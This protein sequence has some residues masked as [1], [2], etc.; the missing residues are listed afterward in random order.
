MK[1]SLKFSIS[2]IIILVLSYLILPKSYHH[3]FLNRDPSI[4]K[5]FENAIEEKNL[6]LVFVGNSILKKDVDFELLNSLMDITVLD[7]SVNATTAPD[8]YLL[9]KNNIVT[10]SRRP[11]TVVIFFTDDRLTSVSSMRG[12]ENEKRVSKFA[13]A[14]ESVF[15]SLVYDISPLERF[16]LKTVTPFAYQSNLRDLMESPFQYGLPKLVYH[17]DPETLANAVE[18]TFVNDNMDPELLEIARQKSEVFGDADLQNTF[19]DLVEESFLPE[20]IRVANEND[21]ELIFARLMTRQYLDPSSQ[22][23]ELVKYIQDLEE[24][25]RESDIVFIDFTGKTPQLAPE[26]FRD[27]DHLND[28]GPPIFTP[29]VVETFKELGIP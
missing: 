16:I 25:L 14:N 2:L 26:D 15:D 8:W 20:L 11:L 13:G 10:S 23:L 24:Y 1:P 9:L 12:E 21:V 3:Y 22:P 27:N 19:A 18:T 5:R 29:I 4:D 6:D 7:A 17:W 28:L